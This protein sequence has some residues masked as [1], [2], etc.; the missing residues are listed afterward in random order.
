LPKQFVFALGFIISS[1]GHAE[2]QQKREICGLSEKMLDLQVLREV[3]LVGTFSWFDDTP[4]KGQTNQGG[5]LHSNGTI[6]EPK[7]S[8]KRRQIGP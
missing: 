3:N 8:N 7:R 5:T 2:L 4:A 1:E 6:I